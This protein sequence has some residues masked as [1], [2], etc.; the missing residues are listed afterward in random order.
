MH[1]SVASHP[2]GFGL[3]HWCLQSFGYLGEIRILIIF[4][5]TVTAEFSTPGISR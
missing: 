5:I 2:H 1:S 3:I 4:V